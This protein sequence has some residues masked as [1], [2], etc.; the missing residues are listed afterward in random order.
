MDREVNQIT[1]V[2]RDT[3][4]K[5]VANHIEKIANRRNKRALAYA[6][7]LVISFFVL[8]YYAYHS[9]QSASGTFKIQ[10]SG[11]Q[12]KID[13]VPILDTNHYFDDRVALVQSGSTQNLTKL[14]TH[15]TISYLKRGE[16]WAKMLTANGQ[17]DLQ[18]NL[19]HFSIDH[20]MTDKDNLTVLRF[21]FSN[22][23]PLV[24]EPHFPLGTPIEDITDEDT[25][26]TLD[27]IK[28]TLEAEAIVELN[29][30][31]KQTIKVRFNF[32]VLPT[33][34]NYFASTLIIDRMSLWEV[35]Q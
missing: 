10:T 16:L 31:N 17:A 15:T 5:L 1:Q 32:D 21:K 6:F 18:A 27:V 14:L 35:I 13:S 33:N 4:S 28:W 22:G 25:R 26:N 7:G 2:E 34:M 11:Q 12:K 19:D 3:D 23:L 8:V 30:K 29:S 24:I 20:A 9:L